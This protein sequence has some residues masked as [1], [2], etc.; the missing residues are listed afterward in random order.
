M[1]VGTLLERTAQRWPEGL[2]LV[3]DS[4]G[5]TLT[6][7]Q[8]ASLAYGAGA[9]LRRQQLVPGDRIAMLG[10]GS[11]DYLA[12]DYGAMSAGLVRV[13]LDPSL[14]PAEQAAQILDAGARVLAYGPEHLERASE[15]S[16]RVA[17]LS[18]VPIALDTLTA[19]SYP[20]ERPPSDALAS[21]NYTGG[22]TGEPKAVMLTHGNLA[23][24]VQNIVL[25]RA[26][27]PGD[28]MLNVRPL[29][30]IAAVI[31]LAHLLAGGTVILG[32]RFEPRRFLGLLERHRATHSSLVPTHLVRLL[33]DED[34]RRYRLEAL[35]SI[36]MGAAAVPPAVFER[37]L[38][39]FGPR[40]GVLYGLTEAS[41]SCYQPAHE[42]DVPSPERSG[43]IACAGRPNFGVELAIADDDTATAGE[44]LI[45]GAHVTPGY[46]KRPDLTL[47]ALRDGWFHTGDLGVIDARG[48]LS[49][50]GR[51]KE[52]IRTGAKSV[53]PEEVEQ[54][55]RSHPDVLEAVVVGL[56]DAEWG[57][58]VAAAVV[59]RP[60]TQ[61]SEA[62]LLE[63]CRARLSS[64]KKP[65][66]IRIFESVPR[67]HYGKVQRGRVRAE[68]ER[69]RGG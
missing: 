40:I 4:T 61:P 13:P 16:E 38:E 53:Q 51:L 9:V 59:P 7:A 69:L 62:E 34:P 3:E 44:I 25:A 29:W 12:W 14:A 52:I 64:F 1:N 11:V 26:A 43:R 37:A 2:A 41:W 65:K 33:D 45:R 17:S 63:H 35:R 56:A 66:L 24:I 42:L 30:P 39:A 32:G 5:R 46:W 20:L 8:F 22:T 23:A 21:L 31:V 49:V 47:R 36:D 27:G 28:K 10:D 67:S 57:E 54:T 55:L 19:V 18:L 58:I 15:L 6:F 48:V 68:L 60:G 50:T